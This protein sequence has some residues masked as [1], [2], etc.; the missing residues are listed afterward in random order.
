MNT[1][2]LSPSVAEHFGSG[3]SHSPAAVLPAG[4]LS[5][6]GARPRARSRAPPVPASVGVVLGAGTER[7]N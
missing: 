6:A 7:P 2:I 5:G 1:R 3:G 4:A